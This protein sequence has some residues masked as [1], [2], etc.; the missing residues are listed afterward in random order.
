MSRAT[1]RKLRGASNGVFGLIA[2][3]AS[4]S[5]VQLVPALPCG[6]TW[7]HSSGLT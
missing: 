6:C 2:D 7:T 4:G 1:H 5:N 3:L